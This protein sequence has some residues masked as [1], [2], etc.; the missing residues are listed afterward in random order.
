MWVFE[1]GANLKADFHLLFNQLRYKLFSFVKNIPS[2][3]K[4]LKKIN[5]T[6]LKVIFLFF[7]KKNVK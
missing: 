4:P 7:F 2:K 6:Q 5:K 3:K 1:R